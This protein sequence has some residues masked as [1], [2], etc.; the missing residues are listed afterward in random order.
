MRTVNALPFHRPPADSNWYYGPDYMVRISEASA[1][2][3]L[4]PHPLPKPGYGTVAVSV[5]VPPSKLLW[6]RAE[7]EVQNISGMFFLASWSHKNSMWPDIFNVTV[8]F[9][10]EDTE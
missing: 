2:K 6:C 10:K 5:K 7:L 3:L 9:P 4:A 8:V 1:K